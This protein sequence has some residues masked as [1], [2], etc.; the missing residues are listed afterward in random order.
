MV[1]QLLCKS[2]N[3]IKT[4]VSFFGFISSVIISPNKPSSV[5]L[6]NGEKIVKSLKN[7]RYP[8]RKFL[9]EIG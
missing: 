2:Q 7:N 4:S 9:D 6:V 8:N 1:A 3:E 5:E